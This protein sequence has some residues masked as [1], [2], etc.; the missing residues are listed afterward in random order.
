MDR[1]ACVS[2]SMVLHKQ[3]QT[4]TGMKR[5]G[6]IVFM[7]YYCFDVVKQCVVKCRSTNVIG[8]FLAA[9]S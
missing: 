9:S 6:L 2:I 5:A 7:T 8:L 4:M 1:I 3:V